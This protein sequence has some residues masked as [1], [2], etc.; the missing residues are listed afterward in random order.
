M[1]RRGRG[2]NISDSPVNCHVYNPSLNC[3]YYKTYKKT[4]KSW[5]PKHE[6]KLCVCFNKNT[7]FQS[8]ESF[9]GYI[10][11]VFL[12]DCHVI[13]FD[14]VFLLEFFPLLTQ[15]HIHS[16]SF[17]LIFSFLSKNSKDEN[18]NNQQHRNQ[19]QHYCTNISYRQTNFN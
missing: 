11:P 12:E 13:Y 10:G 4:K 3:Q 18:Q 15:L 19:C 16:F 5:V 7:V 1:E 9:G 17:S 8:L 2:A 14:H 6:H